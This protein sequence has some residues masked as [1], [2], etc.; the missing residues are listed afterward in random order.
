MVFLAAYAVLL[1]F[2]M[3]NR[4]NSPLNPGRPFVAV[5]I[6]LVA[7]SYTHLDVYKRQV[8]TVWRDGSAARG[9]A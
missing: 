2:C 8:C 1:L 5:L 4:L 6:M 7:V 9:V 3:V